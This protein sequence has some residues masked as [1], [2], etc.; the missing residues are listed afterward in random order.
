MD[1]KE[2]AGS[3]G[4]SF[5]ETIVAFR[6]E[7]LIPKKEDQFSKIENGIDDLDSFI[8]VHPTPFERE[9]IVNFETMETQSQRIGLKPFAIGKYPITKGQFFRFVREI[10][11]EP[12]DTNDYSHRIFLHHWTFNAPPGHKWFHPATFVSYDD[13]L[14]YGAHMKGR[15]PT[16]QEWLYAAFGNTKNEYPWGNRFSPD[17]CNV[18]ETKEMDTTK[19][20]L[21]SPT[22]DSPIG[23]CDIVGNV[24]EWTST[25]SSDA[26][27]VFVAM[28][29]GWDHY[30]FQTE[31]LLDRSYRNRSVG[32]RV[33]RDLKQNTI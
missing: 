6:G 17:R 20:G 33:V 9:I 26:E 18:R 8:E 10:Q 23:C 24:W 19:V 25:P 4:P 2:K 15:L 29:T 30:S 22:G 21:Y 16:Y 5:S 1:L 31:I 7:R 32:F 13:A 11:Y 27:E 3:L 28:G 14:A 12:K